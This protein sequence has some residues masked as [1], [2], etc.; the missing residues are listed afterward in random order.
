VQADSPAGGRG[1]LTD[2]N[3]D[4]ALAVVSVDIADDPDTGLIERLRARSA[5]A[6]VRPGSTILLA[7]TL[8]A[9]ADDAIF[10]RVPVSPFI[11]KA[12]QLAS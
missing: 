7:K 3:G 2:L 1:L 5:C 9:G 11:D 10:L 6:C 8:D 4:I 12:A